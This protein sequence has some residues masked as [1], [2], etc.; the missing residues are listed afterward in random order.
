MNDCPSFS[1]GLPLDRTASVPVWRQIL[2]DIEFE[3]RGGLV[4]SGQKLPSELELSRRYGVN[5][6]TVRMA[7]LKLA[8]KGL[9]VSRQGAGV[10]VT[11]EQPEYRIA[12]QPSTS[13][14]EQAMND[15]TTGELIASYRRPTSHYLAG[16]LQIDRGG[17][18]LVLETLRQA[19]SRLL[20]YGYHYF[21]A[22]RFA[23]ID[24]AFARLRSLSATLAEFDCRR[25]L[26]RATWIDTR[27]PR[28]VE[29][30]AL[31]IDL[32]EPVIVLSYVD[33]DGEG[34]PVLFG[35]TVLRGGTVR[36][37]VETT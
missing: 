23:G 34:R 19:G 4:A 8:D 9:V 18:L 7:L 3:I 1:D 15:A 25:L 27:M 17:E 29:A 16:L 30:A 22:A 11:D 36:V 6:H 20:S 24:T 14:L 13:E 28:K 5:R 37:R 21:D 10:F 2:S 33:T 31:G 35:N 26:R 12:R 32:D